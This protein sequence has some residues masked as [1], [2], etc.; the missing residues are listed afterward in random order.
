[1]KLRQ[2]RTIMGLLAAADHANMDAG[3]TW[4][5]MHQV[6]P[7]MDPPHDAITTPWYVIINDWGEVRYRIWHN[8]PCNASI[9]RPGVVNTCSVAQ[10]VPWPPSKHGALATPI[11]CRVSM[12]LQRE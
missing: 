5:C 8:P 7:T 2:H 1:M 11:A 4:T 10:L 12:G 3:L 6:G 9:G